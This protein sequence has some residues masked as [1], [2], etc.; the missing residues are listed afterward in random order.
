MKK[1]EVNKQQVLVSVYMKTI[2]NC[3]FCKVAHNYPAEHIVHECTEL[4]TFLSFDP[5]RESHA[6]IVTK[7][8]YDYFDDLPA[9]LSHKIIDLGQKIAKAQ[10]LMYAVERVGFVYTGSDIAHVHAH[11][12]PLFEETDITSLQYINRSGK[13]VEMTPDRMA[14]LEVVTSNLKSTLDNG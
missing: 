11:V 6:L 3:H 2:D 9:P 5:I 10:K 12:V 4:I 1:A 8:H 13:P 14:N 7:E